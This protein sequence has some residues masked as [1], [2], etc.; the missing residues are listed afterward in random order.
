MSK[1]DLISVTPLIGGRTNSGVC[2]LLEIGS[3]KILLDC[4]CSSSIDDN[5]HDFLHVVNYVKQL[6]G[7]ISAILISHADIHHMGG[8]PL[9]LGKNGITDIPIICTLPVYKFG[10][11][12]LYDHLMNQLMEGSE[13]KSY[14]F[15]DIDLAFNKVSTVKFNQSINIPNNQH[16]IITVSALRSGRTVGGSM[17]KIRCGPTEILYM[18]DINLKKEI[19]L[20]SV[21]FDILPVSPALMIVE[22]NCVHQ[23][24]TSSSTSSSMVSSDST[25]V[26]DRTS[27]RRGRKDK[28]ESSVFLSFILEKLRSN[29]NVLIPCETV[30]R[31]LELM[32][33]L[34]KFWYDQKLGM[35]NLIFLSHMAKNVPEF[36]R[37][38]LEWMSDSLSKAFYNGKLSNFSIIY[39]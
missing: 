31:T 3:V 27:T 5:N 35:Y 28:D 2:A 17:W 11:V 15:D 37:M 18:M 29:S 36:A 6:K 4:G 19:V 10:Q 34:G 20:D 12:I 1:S 13:L 8:L 14:D 26:S 9:L 24:T 25:I 22:G 7:S 30:G 21:S 39:R 32:Q 38:Q 16:S 33:L 23:A